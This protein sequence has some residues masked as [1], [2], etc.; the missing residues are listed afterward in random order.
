MVCVCTYGTLDT[1]LKGRQILKFEECTVSVP[2][3]VERDVADKARETGPP[4]V[5]VLGDV[6]GFAVLC[7]ASAVAMWPLIR[8]PPL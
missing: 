3:A 7:R 2:L 4:V 5:A 8:P 1:R 6:E